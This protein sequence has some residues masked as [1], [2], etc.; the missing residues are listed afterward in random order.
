MADLS[1]QAQVV[2][3]AFDDDAACD[4]P[5]KSCPMTDYQATLLFGIA[6]IALVAWGTK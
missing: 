6:I 1:P 5:W 2:L 3:D 4:A